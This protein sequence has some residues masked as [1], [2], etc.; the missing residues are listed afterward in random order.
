MTRIT[1]RG[2]AFKYTALSVVGL[3][4]LGT[5]WPSNRPLQS[6]L[7][8]LR[9]LHDRG[10]DLAGL[11]IELIGERGDRL[12]A[13]NMTPNDLELPTIYPPTIARETCHR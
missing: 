3:N 5:R 9:H 8:F 1:L 10:M 12:P 7:C 6:T 2:T 11:E 13:A 4:L